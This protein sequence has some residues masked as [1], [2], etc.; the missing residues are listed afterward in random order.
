MVAIDETAAI[1][2]AKAGTMPTELTAPLNGLFRNTRSYSDDV[3]KLSDELNKLKIS[4]KVFSSMV[5]L[6]SAKWSS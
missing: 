1:R 4:H 5:M 6:R 2:Y 3:Q